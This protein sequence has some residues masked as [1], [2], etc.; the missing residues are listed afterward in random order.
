MGERFLLLI[1]ENPDDVFLILRELRLLDPDLEVR[2]EHDS[3]AALEFLRDAEEL[4]EA[5]L[6][7]LKFIRLSGLELLSELRRQERTRRLPVVLMASGED[8]SKRVGRHVRSSKPVACLS[9][10]LDR[11][12]FSAVLERLGIPLTA[13]PS[14]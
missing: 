4:P 10:P 2:V 11:S 9:K 7:G 13:A 3:A 6:L 1:E 5:L 8:E 14:F 12:T